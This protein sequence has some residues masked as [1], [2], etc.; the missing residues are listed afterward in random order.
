MLE[1]IAGLILLLSLLFGGGGDHK[2]TT[3][4][5]PQTQEVSSVT[6][7]NAVQI[8]T[9]ALLPGLIGMGIAT[10][11]KRNSIKTEA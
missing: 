4:Q 5:K 2:K 6:K 3:A 11:R 10:I 1:T 8:P 9:P 7:T